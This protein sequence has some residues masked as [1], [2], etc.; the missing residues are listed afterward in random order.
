MK[1]LRKV[2]ESKISKNDFIPTEDQFLDF[3]K[4]ITTEIKEDDSCKVV[5]VLHNNNLI[6]AL[7][8]D[9]TLGMDNDKLDM[10]N[11]KLAYNDFNLWLNS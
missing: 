4:D 6:G 11:V 2:Y 1:N 8:T 7:C 9:E 10:E 3:E 5:F